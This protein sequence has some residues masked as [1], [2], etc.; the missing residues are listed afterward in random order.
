[1]NCADVND[2]GQWLGGGVEEP[3]HA[4]DRGGTDQGVQDGR[5][6]EAA[7]CWLDQTRAGV[8][9]RLGCG[10]ARRGT[11]YRGG[12]GVEEPATSGCNWI[13]A[14]GGRTSQG[15]GRRAVGVG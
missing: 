12:S 13:G 14:V 1:M 15:G 8:T 2:G 10:G 9:G 4:G 3:G 7:V 11:G 5:G 6:V